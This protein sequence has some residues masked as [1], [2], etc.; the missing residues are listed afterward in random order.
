MN[1]VFYTSLEVL[2]PTP[3]D[4]R[5]YIDELT[6][7]NL[8]E[9]FGVDGRYGILNAVVFNRT[10]KKFYYFTGTVIPSPDILN[11]GNWNELT[12][13]ATASFSSWATDTQY[14][15]GECVYDPSTISTGIKFFIAKDITTISADPYLTSS[16]WFEI[17]SGGAAQ[18]T[19]EYI[20]DPTDDTTWTLAIEY[21]SIDIPHIPAVQVFGNFGNGSPT[22]QWELIQPNASIIPNTKI[23]NLVFTGD[24]EG[25]GFEYTVGVANIKIVIR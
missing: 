23:I 18:Q 15:R 13:A 24:I 4:K 2:S 1:N 3:I 7:E 19:V 17:G 8:V 10:D 16:E 12:I 22:T 20:L 6:N 5:M 9:L 14:S 11:P 25:A 21:V